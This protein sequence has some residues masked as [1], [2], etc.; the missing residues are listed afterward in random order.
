MLPSLDA[1]GCFGRRNCNVDL[2]DLRWD[3]P[4]ID[5]EPQPA[6]GIPRNLQLD[7]T[8]V[9]GEGEACSTWRRRTNGENAGLSSLQTP[10]T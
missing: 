2:D 4:D 7:E 8:I 10:I 3:R 1:P 9:M 6:R 5:Y